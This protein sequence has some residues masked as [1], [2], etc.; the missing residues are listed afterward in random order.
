MASALC[1]RNEA[2]APIWGQDFFKKQVYSTQVLFP[3]RT[4][5]SSSLVVSRI[6]L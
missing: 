3:S 1:A 6:F 5:T 2:L 4:S